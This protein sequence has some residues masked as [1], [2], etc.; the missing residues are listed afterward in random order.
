MNI[1]SNNSIFPFH[2]SQN[3]FLINNYL[4]ADLQKF[5]YPLNLTQSIA[6]SPKY[7]IRDNFITPNNRKAVCLSFCC[8]LSYILIFVTSIV[9][10]DDVKYYEG[11]LLLLFI[12]LCLITGG[13]FACNF[14]VNSLQTDSHVN[15]VLTV[16]R[17]LNSFRFAKIDCES[18]VR[19]NWIY[20]FVITFSYIFLIGTHLYKAYFTLIL[21][22][23]YVGLVLSDVNVVY[24]IRVIQLLTHI[25]LVWMSE[26][27]HINDIVTDSDRRDGSVRP[28]S[29]WRATVKAYVDITDAARMYEEVSK[30][31]IVYYMLTILFNVLFHVQ[32]ILSFPTDFWS[33]VFITLVWTLKHVILLTIISFATEKFY[34]TL[35][36]TQVLFLKLNLTVECPGKRLSYKT[37]LRASNAAW[38]RRETGLLG[39]NA[40]LPPNFFSCVATYV[41]VLLQFKF[42]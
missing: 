1:I 33:N 6:Y 38:E 7:Y 29:Y 28:G 11:I 36:N 3:E 8:A 37:L 22:L 13:S 18:F 14:I 2:Y 24:M 41:I 15:L 34:M 35:K 17:I 27:K 9:F 16:Q 20:F 10:Y 26:L 23:Y 12:I 31:P 42:T 21:S 30:I 39:V 5:L 4:E 32:I 40:A 19:G 25:T